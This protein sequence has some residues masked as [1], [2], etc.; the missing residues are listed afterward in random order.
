M[1]GSFAGVRPM[2]SSL[3]TDNGFG[4]ASYGTR[5]EDSSVRAVEHVLSHTLE[6]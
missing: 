1:G 3:D 4:G 5:G 2:D 6:E